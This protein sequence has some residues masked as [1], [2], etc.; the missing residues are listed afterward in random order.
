MQF[1]S[2]CSH[3]FADPTNSH[4]FQGSKASHHFRVLPVHIIFQGPIASHHRSPTFFTHCHPVASNLPKFG[5]VFPQDYSRQGDDRHPHYYG[6]VRGEN[7]EFITAEKTGVVYPG[8]KAPFARCNSCHGNKNDP[9][10]GIPGA[11]DPAHPGETFWFMAPASMALELAPGVP[12]K[13]DTLC[14]HLKDKNLNGNRELKDLLHHIETEHLVLWAWHPGTR[15]NG[16]AR[17]TPPLSHEEFVEVFKKWIADG[18]P[19][20]ANKG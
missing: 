15:P 17:T 16:E 1:S 3:H 7:V 20:P 10:T 13:G 5:G 14:T 8:I 18:A 4:V 19:C 12:L 9:E 2:Q 6:V 11:E